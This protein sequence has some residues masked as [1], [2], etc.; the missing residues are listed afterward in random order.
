[1]L[2]AFMQLADPA[3]NKVSVETW[4][5]FFIEYCDPHMGGIIVGN[6]G[7]PAYNKFRIG[8]ILKMFYGIDIEKLGGL[9]IHVWKKVLGIFFDRDIYIPTRRPERIGT[10]AAE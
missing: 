8:V 7:D 2:R 3:T 10:T 1:M 4:D 6:L 9:D 5:R